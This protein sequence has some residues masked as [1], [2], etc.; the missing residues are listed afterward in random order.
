MESEYLDLIQWPAMG[1]TVLAVWFVASSPRG[2]REEGFWLFLSSNTL[3]AI[4]GLHER[5]YALVA[6]QFCLAFMNLRGRQKNAQP[7]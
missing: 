1:I 2:R 5:A 6:M 7:D 3:W 4:W